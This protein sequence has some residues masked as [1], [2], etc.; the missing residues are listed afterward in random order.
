MEPDG[1]LQYSQ[2]SATCPY[3]EPTPSSP[4]DPLQPAVYRLLT[5]HI[6]NR[7]SLFRFRKLRDTPSG[8]TPP[9]PGEPN[10]GVVC[11]QIVLSPKEAS[12]KVK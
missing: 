4:H 2:V 6:P 3:P 1:S 5:F 10:G 11:L 9:P 12:H 8:N 7:M